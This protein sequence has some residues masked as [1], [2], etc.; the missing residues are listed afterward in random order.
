MENLSLTT[1]QFQFRKLVMFLGLRSAELEPMLSILPHFEL[2][3][4]IKH[5]LCVCAATPTTLKKIAKEPANTLEASRGPNPDVLTG[6]NLD[7]LKILMI[8]LMR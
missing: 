2:Q 7:E 4:I 6:N 3:L 8:N 1:G 5:L